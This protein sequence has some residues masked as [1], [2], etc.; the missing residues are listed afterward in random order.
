[1]RPSRFALP[2]LLVLGACA[3][4]QVLER[5]LPQLVG[6]HVDEAV[7]ALG[8]PDRKLTVGAYEIYVWE[9]QSDGTVPVYGTRTS[10]TV[11][12]VG[13]EVFHGTTTHGTVDFVPVRRGCRIKLQVDAEQIVQRAEFDGDAVGCRR[14]AERLEAFL[15]RGA[16]RPASD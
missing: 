9:S 15:G 16:A 13:G 10:T 1:M 3:S 8:L 11:G 6:R 2:L 12:V 7:E 14:Y 5:G 4:L